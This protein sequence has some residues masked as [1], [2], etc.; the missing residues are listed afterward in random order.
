MM[1]VFMSSLLLFD[2]V[3]FLS[4][5][6]LAVFCFNGCASEGHFEA[7]TRR[8]I[9]IKK[10]STVVRESVSL[11]PNLE[12]PTVPRKVN[13]YIVGT[14]DVLYISVNGNTDFGTIVNHGSY[15]STSTINSLK[16]YRVDGLGCVYLPLTGKLDVAGL[17]LS[18]VRRR[19]ETAVLKYFSN[20]SIVV[21][22][23]EY[24]SRQ[25]FIFGAVKKPGPFP[26]P[27]T[28]INLAQLISTADTNNSVG[29]FRK[30]RIIRSNSPTEGELI[31]VDFEKMLRGQALPVELQEGD[32]VYIPR[33]GISTWNQAIADLLPSLQA[34]G[35]TLQPFVNI[36]YLKQ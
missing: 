19:I 30:V 25:V 5:M 21:E 2:K 7:G 17:P 26:M 22:I 20:P 31:V 35:A 18:E 32:I 16:G 9:E 28:G 6:M 23:A 36:K 12:T 10:D 27:V 14:N 8:I 11:L 4:L 24:R 34:V 3:R 33:S 1:K 15:S 13:D 29:K